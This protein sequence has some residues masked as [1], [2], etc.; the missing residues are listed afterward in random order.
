MIMRQDTELFIEQNVLL[1]DLTIPFVS[2]RLQRPHRLDNH[3]RLSEYKE[4][5]YKGVGWIQLANDMA[6]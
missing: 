6:L 4:T 1:C 3:G 2:Q 5:G